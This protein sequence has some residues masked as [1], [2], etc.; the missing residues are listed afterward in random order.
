MRSWGEGMEQTVSPSHWCQWRCTRLTWPQTLASFSAPLRQTWYQIP[1]K[2]LIKAVFPGSS[3]TLSK[4]HILHL[5]Q[6]RECSRTGI[7]SCL[8]IFGKGEMA[9]QSC[10]QLRERKRAL[11]CG[12]QL[13]KGT[14][15]WVSTQYWESLLQDSV[16]TTFKSILHS[17]SQE[18]NIFKVTY[19]IY[20]ASLNLVLAPHNHYFC[21]QHFQIKSSIILF[22]QGDN[23]NTQNS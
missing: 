11:P 13:Q 1:P 23:T 16:K 22:M 4:V 9:P 7:C 15:S 18:V 3:Q 6:R 19:C 21:L 2:A 17:S 10:F 14:Y 12:S 8:F 20:T 5:Q